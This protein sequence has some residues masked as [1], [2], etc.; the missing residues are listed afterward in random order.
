MTAAECN[1]ELKISGLEKQRAKS[2][3]FIGNDPQFWYTDIPYYSKVKY[4]NIYD[5]I[6]LLFYGHPGFLE[7]DYIVTP[8]GNPEEIKL[9]HWNKNAIKLF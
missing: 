9:I 5:G 1:K 6:D 7:F 2:N 8:A 4:D 3:Y